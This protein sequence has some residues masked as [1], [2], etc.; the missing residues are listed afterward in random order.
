[1]RHLEEATSK[2][3]D[4]P[5]ELR[6]GDT[7]R[8]KVWFGEPSIAKSVQ[9]SYYRSGN[10]VAIERAKEGEFQKVDEA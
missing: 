5:R 10:L 9:Q 2:G 8:E 6:W 7:V 3:P 1:M 4:L